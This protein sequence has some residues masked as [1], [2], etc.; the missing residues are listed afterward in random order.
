MRK[1]AYKKRRRK[2]GCFALL[3]KFIFFILVIAG[4][5]FLIYKASSGVDLTTKIRR[6]QYPI[7]YGHF[8]EKYSK[9]YN[10]DKYLVYAVITT[11]SKFDKYAVSAANAKGL[12]QLTDKTGE[13]CARKIGFSDYSSDA[14]FDPEI[15]IRLGCYYLSSLI[16]LYDRRLDVALA[17]YNGGPGNVEKWL[18]DKSCTDEY[19]NLVKIPFDETKNYVKRVIQARE[20]YTEIYEVKNEGM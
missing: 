16:Q 1:A 13:E 20:M 15:N 19:G 12:M 4:A 6:T 2:N 5:A 14:L 7:K 18:A 17:A 10:L 9:E 8:V 11:E 3:F